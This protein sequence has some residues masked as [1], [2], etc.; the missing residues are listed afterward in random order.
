M[1]FAA[2]D[3]FEHVLDTQHWHLIEHLG[4]EFHLPWFLTKY[5][6]LEVVAAV[7][8]VMIFVPLAKRVQ[9]G[10]P[11]RGRWWN[12]F[13]AL[14]TFIRDQ[15]ARPCIGEEDA[16]RFLPFLWTLFL[17]ILFC[18]LLG[19]VPFLGSPT[20]SI[21]VTG[22]LALCS[23]LVIHGS[24]IARMG[25]V[26]Y[27]KSHAPH[28]DGAIAVVLVPGIVAIEI[29]GHFIKA[30]ILAVRLFANLFAGHMVLAMLLLFIVMAKD[31]GWYLFWPITITSVLG[32][33]ALSLLELF[34][35]F[36]QAYIFVFLTSLFLGMAL[37]PQH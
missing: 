9:S 3:P 15:V 21:S 32:V 11:P 24:A 17:F 30:T 28:L 5:M 13:E 2:A 25:P 22:A 6:V 29:M 19:L 18:N 12:A 10:E 36:L 31:A 33:A 8:I 26:Q 37:H 35:S 20:A 4:W 7:L 34:V 14:L 23:F 1:L 16:D 27:V